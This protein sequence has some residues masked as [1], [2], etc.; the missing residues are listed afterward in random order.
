M[1]N[2][3]RLIDLKLDSKISPSLANSKILSVSIGHGVFSRGH[4]K[5]EEARGNRDICFVSYAADEDTDED[6][7]RRVEKHNY[8]LSFIH[9]HGICVYIDFLLLIARLMRLAIILL[10]EVSW[11]R[12]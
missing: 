5:S 4:L 11:K 1:L 9:C 2:K 10:A 12:N 3:D 8:V 7:Y 6:V